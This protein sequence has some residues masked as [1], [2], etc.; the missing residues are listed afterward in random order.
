MNK[1]NKTKEKQQ[2]SMTMAKTKTG[3]AMYNAA[4][5]SQDD[6]NYEAQRCT[7]SLYTDLTQYHNTK[8]LQ[9]YINI[10]L[11]AKKNARKLFG[12]K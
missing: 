3:G 10:H 7:T 4:T 5:H 2:Q 8:R 1:I 11:S 9:L 6:G 12:T